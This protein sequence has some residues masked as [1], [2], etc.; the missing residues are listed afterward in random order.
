MLTNTIRIV[1]MQI[2]LPVTASVGNYV[3]QKSNE[4]SHNFF[5]KL[6]FI[7]AYFAICCF[8][9]LSTLVN[10]FI[11][12]IWGKEYVFSALITFLITFNFYLDRMRITSQIFIDAKGLFWPIKWKSLFEAA[13]NLSFSFYFLLVLKWG[14]ESVIIATIISNLTTNIW[15]EPYVVFKHGFQ[16]KVS[17]YYITILKYTGILGISYIAAIY[18]QSFFSESFSGFLGKSFIALLVPNIIIILFYFK[19]KELHYFAGLVKNIINKKL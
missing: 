19:T 14:V 13:I 16:K 8:I 12:L 5:N 18:L 7:N 10:P 2:M 11:N 17:T 4:E 15:W 1:F 9:A 6:F 3:A